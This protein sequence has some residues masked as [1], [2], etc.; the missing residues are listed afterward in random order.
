MVKAEGFA[1]D[2]SIIAAD[3]NKQRSVPGTDPVDWSSP[4]LSTRAVREYLEGL[5]GEALAEAMPKRLSL[6]EP[7]S[8]WTAAPGGPA[9]LAYSPNYLIATAPSVITGGGT[10]GRRRVGKEGGEASRTWVSPE[11]SQKNNTTR[12]PQ[13]R[14]H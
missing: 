2:A 6:T 13:K 5:D 7:Q 1:V 8:S 9:I 10:T 3:A 11:N 12:K 4:A 14:Q